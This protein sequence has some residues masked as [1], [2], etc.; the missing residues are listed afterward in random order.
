M[1]R[2]LH[3]QQNLL[4]VAIDRHFLSVSSQTLVIEAIALMSQARANYILIIENEKLLS[5]FTERVVVKLTAGAKNISNIIISE[6]MTKNI[7][8]LKLSQVDNIYGVLELLRSS[9]IHHLPI[10]NDT[11]KILG[12]ITQESIQQALKHTDLLQIGQIEQIMITSVITAPLNASL[13]EIAQ[14]MTNH[15]KSCIVICE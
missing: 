12:V 8:S 13:W 1:S 11:D 6:I 4:E 10:T 14:K 5:I 3:Q 15:C 2:N 9:R 7:I